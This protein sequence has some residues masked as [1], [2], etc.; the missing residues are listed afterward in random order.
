M[1]GSAYLFG[2]Y[3]IRPGEISLFKWCVLQERQWSV[4]FGTDINLKLCT[5]AFA[6][7][8]VTN[9][10]Y[11]DINYTEILPLWCNARRREPV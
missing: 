1:G 8:F 11:I 10:I 6:F 9:E 5:F 2:V 3:C 4:E 7:V